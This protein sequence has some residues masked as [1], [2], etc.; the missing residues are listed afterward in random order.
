MEGLRLKSDKLL[1]V[2]LL[3]DTLPSYLTSGKAPF[4]LGKWLLKKVLL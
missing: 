4:F 2:D 3:P 1:G